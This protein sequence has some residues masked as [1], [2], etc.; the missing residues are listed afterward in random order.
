MKQKSL[1]RREFLKSLSLGTTAFFLS[2]AILRASLKKKK[3]NIIVIFCDDLGYGDL[4]T[5]GH[6]TIKTPNLDKMANQGQKWTNFY[7][8][9]SVCT[10]SRAGLM[11]GRYPIR[12]GMCSDKKRV[13]FPYSLGGLPQSEI[14]IARAL[15]NVGYNTA[16]I[17]KW[18]LGHLPQYLPTK[19][20][21]NYYF[22]IPYSNDM[23]A[24]RRL[25]RQ[26]HFNPDI[27]NYNVP[28][29]KNEE[30]IERPANQNTITKRYSEEAVKFIQKNGEKPF[31]IYLAHN[32]PHI[33]LFTSKKFKDTSARGLY[34]DVVEE[35][36]FGIGKIIETLKQQGLEE[37]TLIVFTS[38]NGPW[39]VFKE[40][41]GSAGLLKGGKGMTWEGGMREPA[42]F[43]WKGKI[44]PDVISDI[45]S[46]LDLF[47]TICSICSAEVPSDRKMDS[48]DLSPVLFE[49]KT[50]PRTSFIYYRGT[51]I[52]AARKGAFKAHFITQKAYMKDKEKIYHDPPV[53]YNL[54][55][56]PS[57]KYDIA[58]KYPEVI[59]EIRELVETHV[60]TVKPVE[61]QLEKLRK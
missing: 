33:P 36:D 49:G 1:N 16:C 28:L 15:K 5:F 44:K 13:L 27:K 41:G 38:D 53:L 9:A 24:V 22:G 35:I 43:Y 37:N 12:N 21:F 20:G 25:K 7:A 31:F 39:L 50:S 42:I 54:D 10:P 29:M 60:K 17:G 11:T 52:Y 40:H 14:T 34:G 19:H 30:I 45:G 23:D 3:P 55:H 6:P 46:T 57:E 47:S 58:E 56:D 32:L 26:D 61:S 51:E 8:A 4:G 18:H 2:P 59:R 48:N